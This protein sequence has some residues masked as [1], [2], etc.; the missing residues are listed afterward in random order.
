MEALYLF[1]EVNLDAMTMAVSLQ[2]LLPDLSK[3][4]HFI[5]GWLFA[6]FFK[7][8]L[9]IDDLEIKFLKVRVKS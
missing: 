5:S 8:V 3:S 4:L 7:S 2:G 6:T 1:R 9:S